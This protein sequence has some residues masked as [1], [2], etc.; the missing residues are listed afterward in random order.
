MTFSPSAILSNTGLIFN[1]GVKVPANRAG[2]PPRGSL[3]NPWL[4]Y[5]VDTLVTLVGL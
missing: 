3:G 4:C 5:I 2:T 1:L